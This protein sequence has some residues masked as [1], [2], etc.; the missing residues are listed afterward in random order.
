MADSEVAT[1]LAQ[2]RAAHA[3]Y[4]Q[5]KA[6]FDPRLG[7]ATPGNPV[8]K[9][10]A[11]AKAALLRTQAHTIDPKHEDPAWQLDTVPHIELL[12]FYVSELAK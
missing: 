11:L 4:Q 3:E 2:S 7:A 12:N 5:H 1:L 10:T 8:L 6:R 9:R